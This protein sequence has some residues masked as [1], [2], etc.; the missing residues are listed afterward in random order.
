MILL[1]FQFHQ[2]TI[3]SVS[4]PFVLLVLLTFQ[5][6]Q[7]TITSWLYRHLCSVRSKFQFH[8]GTITRVCFFSKYESGSIISIPSRYNYK[9]GIISGFISSPLFQ[10]HQGTI[11]S[12]KDTG[13]LY[14]ATL[15]Q[16]HQGTITRPF[17]RR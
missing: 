1:T 14:A 6:H 12:G 16:F 15:F 17:R 4:A 11:T 7:G 8:Q 5:F 9:F 3:T 10:F 2:G 13:S